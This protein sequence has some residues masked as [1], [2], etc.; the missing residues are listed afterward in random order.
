MPDEQEREHEAAK[1]LDAFVDA[2]FAFAVTLL[3]IAGAEATSNLPALW[4][5]MGRIPA[6]LGAFALISLFWLA[7]RDFGR[8]APRRDLAST[9]N[10]LAIVFVVLVYVFPLRMLVESGFVWISRGRLPGEIFIHTLSDLRQLF[11]VYGLGFAV[12][13][14]LFVSLFA[15]A[16]RAADRLGVTPEG[17]AIASA[18]AQIWTIVASAGVLSALL[19]FAP[20]QRAPWLPGF[21]Y[22]S[23]P[24]AI[25]IR[26]WWV[27]RPKA[28][29]T[30][31][32]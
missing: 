28:A 21:A 6:S 23:I 9:L 31:V 30:Q 8:L 26:G 29:L 14:G 25:W 10:G 27:S 17:A 12:L 15:H 13:A 18:S 4:K 19:T 2:A 7:Y 16:A 11:L 22:W 24:V 5:A 20:L 3:V 1:R 32:D